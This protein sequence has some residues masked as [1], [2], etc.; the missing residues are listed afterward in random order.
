[1]ATEV[2]IRQD[3]GKNKV[4]L[5]DARGVEIT[6][7][8]HHSIKVTLQKQDEVVIGKVMLVDSEGNNVGD[9]IRKFLE[10]Q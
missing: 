4:R 7:S 1:M 6:D 10:K 5:T 2:H 8:V 9:L 3:K